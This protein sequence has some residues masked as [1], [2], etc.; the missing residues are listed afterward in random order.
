MEE[1][2]KLSEE[3]DEQSEISLVHF[4]RSQRYRGADL[5]FADQTVRPKYDRDASV[6]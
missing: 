3:R 6:S 1:A 5:V 2:E 4:C